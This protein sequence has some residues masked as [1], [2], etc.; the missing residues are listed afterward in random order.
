MLPMVARGQDTPINSQPSP[1]AHSLGCS[2]S[3]YLTSQKSHAGMAEP[4]SCGKRVSDELGQD[5]QGESYDSEKSGSYTWLRFIR[6]IAVGSGRF[7][8]GKRA[9][10]RG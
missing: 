8:Q 7:Q 5:V 6:D 9:D 1:A 2:S 10:F 3:L 4:R